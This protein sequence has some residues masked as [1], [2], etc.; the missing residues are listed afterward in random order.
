MWYNE[1]DKIH[2]E[3]LPG[4]AVDIITKPDDPDKYPLLARL[5]VEAGFDWV[6]LKKSHVHC[7]VTSGR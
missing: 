4:R 3:I 5:A 2:R 1:R 6:R 7:S